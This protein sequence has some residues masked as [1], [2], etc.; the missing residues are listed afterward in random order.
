[1]I[2]QVEKISDCVMKALSQVGKDIEAVRKS[3]Q[4][5]DLNLALSKWEATRN[6]FEEDSIGILPWFLRRKLVPIIRDAWV[7]RFR[8]FD[9]VM[10]KDVSVYMSKIIQQ[11][12]GPSKFIHRST[13]AED[14]A[15]MFSSE[16]WC[17][18]WAD[19][20][21]TETKV[22][23]L[24]KKLAKSRDSLEP[25]KKDLRDLVIQTI[26]DFQPRCIPDGKRMDAESFES[27]KRAGLLYIPIQ[28]QPNRL[29]EEV[30]SIAEPLV[31][32]DE[33][34]VELNDLFEANRIQTWS[35]RHANE[36]VTH[37]YLCLRSQPFVWTNL[38]I[39][40]YDKLDG[41]A[42]TA[43]SLASELKYDRSS[44][45]QRGIK[46]LIEEG[47]I[48]NLRGLG[49]YRPDAPPSELSKVAVAS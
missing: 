29:V 28:L 8:L 31:S 5:G 22:R 38:R 39:R 23:S 37:E 36:N 19:I 47:L 41:R 6:R 42:L 34:W 10:P 43:D 46:P 3:N 2:F 21:K 30:T 15:F 45:L 44:L 32:M 20:E 9:A 4:G 11:A 14:A 16:I 25:T 17:P 18:I 35:Y 12:G 7:L 49:Y 24:F 13:N 27:G 33:V 26:R 40:I 48:K 1:M